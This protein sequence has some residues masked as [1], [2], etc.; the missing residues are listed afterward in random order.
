MPELDR[1]VCRG[2]KRTNRLIKK[3]ALL[4]VLAALFWAY[5]ALEGERYLS[6]DFFRGLYLEQP[7]LTA[8]VYFIVYVITAALSIPGA[9]LLT[10]IGGM[11]FGLWT[12]TLL[13]SFASS[14]GATLAFLV[15][16]FLLR[17]WVQQKFSAH[18]GTINKGIEK[19]GGFYLFSLRLIPLFPFWMINLVMGL[20]PIKT[21]TFYWVSQLGM[22]AGTLVYV[23]AGASLNNIE[24]FSP[25]AY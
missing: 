8:A 25:S 15:S 7:L 12:G 17:D 10:I 13:V 3:I 19:Q 14:V 24:E 20:T 6:L 16:R 4:L 9:A 5:I 22:L 1:R 18:L 11:V 2:T 21:I 23:N